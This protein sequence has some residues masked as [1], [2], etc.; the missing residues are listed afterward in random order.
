MALCVKHALHLFFTPAPPPS[1]LLHPKGNLNVFPV[2]SRTS[3]IVHK[4]TIIIGTMQRQ[5]GGHAYFLAIVRDSG[6]LKWGTLADGNLA[7]VVTTS[8]TLHGGVVYGGVSS[9]EELVATR[10][11]DCFCAV[12]CHVGSVPSSLSLLIDPIRKTHTHT[13]KTQASITPA[14]R[15][16]AARSRSTPRPAPSSGGAT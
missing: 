8:P 1:F 4:D 14:A 5:F 16:A 9:L 11:H 6:D 10:E 7:A 2:M 13:Q 3:P 15:S 12:K